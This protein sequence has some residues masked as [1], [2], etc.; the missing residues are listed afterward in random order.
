MIGR[1]EYNIGMLVVK[2]YRRQGF[3]TYILKF[4]AKFCL[5]NNWISTAGCATENIGSMKT[6]I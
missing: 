2:E 1:S 6:I 4:M 5:E 3:A